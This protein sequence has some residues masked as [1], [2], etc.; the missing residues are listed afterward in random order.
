MSSLLILW[1]SSATRVAREDSVYSSWGAIVVIFGF[2]DCEW[3]LVLVGEEVIVGREGGDAE[4]GVD[5]K[6]GGSA[7]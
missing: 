1:I 2:A 6:Q 5:G 7:Q 3:C 4:G